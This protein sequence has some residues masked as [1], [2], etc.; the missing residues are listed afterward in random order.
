M[1]ISDIRD[2]FNIISVPKGIRCT[3]ALLNYC[4]KDGKSD[5]PRNHQQLVF[6]CVNV[7]DNTGHR[8]T[9]AVLPPGAGVLQAAQDVALKAIS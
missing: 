2:A 7:N 4:D 8:Y 5:G 1:S 3:S 9:S 6:D